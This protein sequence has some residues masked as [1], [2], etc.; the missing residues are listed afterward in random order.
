MHGIVVRGGTYQ[1]TDPF[2]PVIAR[3]Q[4]E[5]DVNAQEPQICLD[6]YWPS[7][8][9]LVNSLSTRT[10][11]LQKAVIT[12]AQFRCTS[13]DAATVTGLERVYDSL[14]LEAMRS[15]SPNRNWPPLPLGS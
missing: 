4:Q 5:W 13:G 10:G 11:L 8:F 15:T 3:P 2:D 9:T 12:P 6:A 1:D 14:E 7:V